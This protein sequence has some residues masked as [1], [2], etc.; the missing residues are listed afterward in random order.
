MPHQRSQGQL[1]APT[2]DRQ[3][4]SVNDDLP[5]EKMDGRTESGD[6]KRAIAGL[7]K[8][9]RMLIDDV[10]N[11]IS[12]AERV[13]VAAHRAAGAAGKKGAVVPRRAAEEAMHVAMALI[14]KLNRTATDLHRVQMEVMRAIG[15]ID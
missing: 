12:S 1:V 9:L 11:Q 15:R 6:V 2:A 4:A 7:G 8:S 14:D 10:H 5:E 13:K 3:Q